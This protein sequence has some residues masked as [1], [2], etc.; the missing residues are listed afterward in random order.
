MPSPKLT[1]NI[2]NSIDLYEPACLNDKLFINSVIIIS[3][4]LLIFYHS[5]LYHVTANTD[6]DIHLKLKLNTFF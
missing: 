1:H 5:R 3:F 2:T 4:L 6:D